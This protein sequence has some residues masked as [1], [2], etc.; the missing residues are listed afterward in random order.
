MDP[1]VYVIHMKHRVDRYEQFLKN[2]TAAGQSTE[3]LHWH[4]A[5]DGRTLSQE[6]LASFKGVNKCAR[7]RAAQC[8]CY[9]SHMSA[10]AAAIRNNH[11]PL[12]ILEDDAVISG[13]VD[14]GAVMLSTPD[15]SFLLYLGGLP[16]EGRSRAKHYGVREE[17]WHSIP[18][19]IRMYGGHAYALLHAVAAEHVLA[20]LQKY[21][22]ALDTSLVRYQSM[23]HEFVFAYKS[24][25]FY[26]AAGVSD[27]S[28]GL[29]WTS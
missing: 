19:G 29:R 14:L 1:H 4:D 12:L 26:Q 16:V 27:I 5:V 25:L 23:Y 2:W 20:H 7:T 8:G 13:P 15:T 24:F 28:G 18:E 22:G 6:T 10:I 21:S 17:G 3:K 9:M 11:F